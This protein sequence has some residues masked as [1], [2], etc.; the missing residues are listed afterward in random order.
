MKDRVFSG[1]FLVG[2]ILAIVVFN[3]SFPLAL[4]IAVAVIAA[5]AVYEMIKAI[6]LDRRWFII[7]PSMITAVAVQFVNFQ[8]ANLLIYSLYVAAIFCAMLRYHK[9]VSVSDVSVAMFMIV[10]IPLALQCIVMVRNLNTEHGIFYALVCIFSAWI[11]DCG[12]FFAGKFFGKHKLCP[13]I[14]PKKTVEGLIGGVVCST[15]VLQLAGWVYST[16]FYGGTHDVSWVSMLIIGLA[17]SLVST[18]GDL[19]FSLI[20]RSYKIKDYGNV[21]PGH[22]GILDRFDS[23]IFTAPFV[24]LVTY[25]L[26]MVS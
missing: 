17:G 18:L 14:S 16:F 12:A 2:F 3:F 9:Q 7:V 11:P 1:V 4:N 25:L 22:G 13:V 21:I 24:Y 23:V 26:P 10:L 8:D 5:I 20:K 19:S 15:L 6:G